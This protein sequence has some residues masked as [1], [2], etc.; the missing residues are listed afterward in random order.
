MTI[1]NIYGLFEF[2]VI[3]LGVMNVAAVHVSTHMQ[4]V[5]VESKAKCSKE[6]V[7]PIW[8]MLFFSEPLRESIAKNGI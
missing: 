1:A 5:L 8:M 6:F 4:K 2:R 3:M 7:I